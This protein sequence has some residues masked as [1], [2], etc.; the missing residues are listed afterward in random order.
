M[1]FNTIMT[2][3]LSSGAYDANHTSQQVI[4]DHN[5][6]SQVTTYPQDTHHSTYVDS[7]PHLNPQ[8]QYA[9]Q[10]S[11]IDPSTSHP[12]SHHLTHVTV[13]LGHHPNFQ[14]EY[15]YAN[16]SSYV[17]HTG[18]SRPQSM[19]HPT[20]LD[21]GSHVNPQN[22][23]INQPS[24]DVD[25]STSYS[26]STHHPTYIT[27]DSGLHPNPQPEDLY[28]NQ[29]SYVDPTGTSNPQ[30]VHYPTYVDSGSHVSPQDPY[31]NQ[32]SCDVEPSTSYSRS[33]HHSSYITVDSGLHPNPQNQYASQ[34]SYVDS[35]TSQSMHH[36]IPG[37][38]DPESMDDLV[39]AKS[40][41][42]ST[43]IDSRPHTNPRNQSA[44]HSHFS[45]DHPGPEQLILVP[46]TT[47]HRPADGLHYHHRAGKAYYH[48]PQSEMS[49]ERPDP[50]AQSS[51]WMHSSFD[52]HNVSDGVEGEPSVDLKPAKNQ[53]NFNGLLL[54]PNFK[55]TYS[56]MP[57]LADATK[58]SP[59]VM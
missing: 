37:T 40:T 57:Y 49:Y 28:T 20:Y 10:S 45:N 13:D 30:S 44:N 21:S 9:N 17:D 51:D 59:L 25:P 53:H 26:Q 42:V 46:L 36:P 23:Y 41:Y 32:P 14:P 54:P 2:D 19:H 52:V 6:V 12:Q 58:I 35:S 47:H 22:Q 56:S 27:V 7:G 50:L 31:A 29:S 4:A 3:N 16:Q 11:S 55:S 24:C 43:Y 15:L 33:T 38:S 8:D 48:T 5:Q 1:H 18:T 39:Y 34:S